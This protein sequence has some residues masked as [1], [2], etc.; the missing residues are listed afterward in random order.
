MRGELRCPRLRWSSPGRKPRKFDITRRGQVRRGPPPRPRDG[1]RRL[2]KI[3]GALVDA[4]EGAGDTLTLVELCEV[5]HRSRPRDLRRRVLPM[6]EEAGIISVDGDTVALT[7]DWLG[8]LEEAR[9]LG[10]EI[11][12]AEHD[13]ERY[14]RQRE[15]FRRRRETAPDPH[16][17]N[18]RGADGHVEDLR[19]ADDPEP[20]QPEGQP[21]SLLAVAV[22]DYLERN[23]RDACQP[24]GWIG[25][26]LWTFEL[27]PGKPT[28]AE[29]R[30]AIEELGGEA[31]LRERLE[32]GKGAA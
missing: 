23:P 3:R 22:R 6:L 12:R 11:E 27:Y 28:P 21:I 26:T 8:R 29:T 15:A 25:S 9:E 19:P 18:H 13:A 24:P 4:L 16:F 10:G 17:A 30:A 31:Y 2:G 5:L 14:R 32:A 1:I 20:P 7:A